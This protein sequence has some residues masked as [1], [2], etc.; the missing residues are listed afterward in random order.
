MSNELIQKNAE[1]GR[2]LFCERY[3]LQPVKNS[4]YIAEGQDLKR[5]AVV[6]VKGVLVGTN[7]SLMPYAVLEN[8]CDTRVKG[9]F[10]S[11]FVKGEFN[12]DKLFFADGLSKNDLDNIVY[13]GSGIGLVF[14][15]YD[16]DSSFAPVMVPT[17]TSQSNP[18]MNAEDVERMINAMKP[19]DAMTLRFDF[20]KKDYSP[21]TAE[22]GSAG[23]WTKVNSPTLNIWDW[24]NENTN[25]KD[26]FNKAF[27]NENNEVRVI[28]AGDTSS[29]TDM[30]N[31][32]R[33]DIT[34]SSNPS[35]SSYVVNAKNNLVSCVPLKIDSCT[36]MYSFFEGTHL[37]KFVQFDY[38]NNKDAVCYC[39]YASTDIEEIGDIVISGNIVGGYFSHNDKL[40]KVGNILLDSPN[41]NTSTGFSIFSNS[42]AFIDF[43]ILEEVGNI[44][45]TSVVNDFSTLFQN[46]V[47]LKKVGSIDVSSGSKFQATFSR[48]HNLEEIPNLV[49]LGDT[50][51]TDIYLMFKECYKLKALPYFDTSSVTNGKGAFTGCSEVKEIPNYDFS[52][53][54]NAE[55]MFSD[56]FK[57]SKN[58]IETYEKLLARGTAIT[59][60]SDC[61]TNCGI[62]T[63]EGRASLA[64]I[65]AS[66][67]GLAQ[68]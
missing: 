16:Y 52:S 24:T 47:S 55:S 40:K 4:L 62:D 68:S 21:V 59:D 43:N 63:N 11:V 42:K 23:T 50:A 18:L 51:V 49:G 66:W 3:T 36:S 56:D 6:D 5:G 10:A 29:V 54:T 65:P 25:W 34:G 2:F 32:F 33:G 20:S 57:V 60:H 1:L 7:N 13:N 28:A 30:G 46:C 41:Y 37:K 45:G 26:S 22:V 27:L 44:T 48:C 61:F 35:S 15:P 12:F 9:A 53:I 58:I 67:G 19:I 17:G 64:Q 39:M 8:D 14:K 31:M 38:S